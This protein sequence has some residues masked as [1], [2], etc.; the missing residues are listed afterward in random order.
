MPM[1]VIYFFLGAYAY[2]HRWFTE[3]GYIPSCRNWVPA[4]LVL[5]AAYV[6]MKIGLAAQLEPAA[7]MAVNALLH[8]LF[9]LVAVFT[10]LSV[11]QRFFGH[12]A[13]LG[14]AGG[15][16]L[17]HLFCPSE[18]RTGN[19]LA[20]TAAGGQCLHKVFYCLRGI[21]GTL[22]FSEPIFP[23]IPAALSQA[24]KRQ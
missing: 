4:F 20:G 9:C 19:G 22:L 15:A 23:G 7:F 11:F 13:P 12:G 16:F 1:Y 17:S 18:Y 8:S 24:V 10:L 21:P 14:R 5:S 2:R 6:W 3:E